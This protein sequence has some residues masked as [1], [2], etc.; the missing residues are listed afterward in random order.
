MRAQ[1][2]STVKKI[3]E[4]NEVSELHKT[5]IAVPLGFMAALTEL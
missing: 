2:G 1:A 3:P 5:P 4:S